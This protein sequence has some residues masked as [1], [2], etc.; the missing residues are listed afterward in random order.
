MY[1]KSQRQHFCELEP[2]LRPTWCQLTEFMFGTEA[3]WAVE[4]PTVKDPTVTAPLETHGAIAS[5][6]MRS[7]AIHDQTQF[8][9]LTAS[10]TCSNSGLLVARAMWAT[11]WTCAPREI[12][13]L[14]SLPRSKVVYFSSVFTLGAKLIFTAPRG[15][16]ETRQSPL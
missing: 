6:T 3:S 15:I 8:I 4:I 9:S 7:P 16:V 13:N 14:Y 1:W 10:Y 2:N 5:K 11:C 12:P